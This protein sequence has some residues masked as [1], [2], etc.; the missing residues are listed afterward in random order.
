MIFNGQVNFIF[1]S[2]TWMCTLIV[3]NTPALH[4]LLGGSHG[5]THQCYTPPPSLKMIPAILKPLPQSTTYLLLPYH[6][7]APLWFREIKSHHSHLLLN[8]PPPFPLVPLHSTLNLPSPPHPQFIC[9]CAPQ[10][11]FGSFLQEF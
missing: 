1:K 2:L 4:D 3:V 6:A 11:V 5:T 9:V 10:S 8:Y 7:N